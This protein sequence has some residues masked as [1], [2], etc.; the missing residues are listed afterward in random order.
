MDVD[1]FLNAMAASRPEGS[2]NQFPLTVEA[3]DNTSDHILELMSYYGRALQ[4]L[5]IQ[6]HPDLQGQFA[7]RDFGISEF[8]EEGRYQV[9]PRVIG[10]IFSNWEVTLQTMSP[11]VA[12]ELVKIDAIAE[13]L[14]ST[15]LSVDDP[16]YIELMNA[17]HAISFYDQ[18]M[19]IIDRAKL[20]MSGLLKELPSA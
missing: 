9:L 16:R 1:G 17:Y 14:D 4:F 6:R 11:S 18:S 7:A 20:K 8:A 15:D 13:S 3:V 12:R 10:G 2:Y 5:E 19:G